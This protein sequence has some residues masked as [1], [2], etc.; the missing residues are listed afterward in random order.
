MRGNPEKERVGTI[1]PIQ[2]TKKG[3]YIAKTTLH[4]EQLDIQYGKGNMKLSAT[5]VD[6]V[7]KKEYIDSCTFKCATNKIDIACVQETHDERIYNQVYGDYTI[8]YSASD[9]AINNQNN[10][11]THRAYNWRGGVAIVIKNDYVGHIKQVNR[12]LGE[13]LK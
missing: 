9:R 5:N 12:K 7:R 10:N 3:I 13:L 2:I 8:F 11:N 1:S 4:K 6:S